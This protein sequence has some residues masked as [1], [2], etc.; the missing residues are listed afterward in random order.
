M[1]NSNL[2][3]MKK[4]NQS[5]N[6]INIVSC[7]RGKGGRDQAPQTCFQVYRE[8]GHLLQW[9]SLEK[10]KSDRSKGSESRFHPLCFPQQKC[11]FY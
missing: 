10:M 11:T 5:T 9:G 4:T 8:F 3:L 7:F 1:R 2:G 6:P